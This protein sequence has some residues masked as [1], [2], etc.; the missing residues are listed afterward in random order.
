MKRFKK[1]L[2][3]LIAIV[4]VS[5]ITVM[6][7]SANAFIYEKEAN[8]LNKLGLYKG[9]NESWFDP[10]L[11]ANLDRQTGVVMLLR[12]FGQEDEAKKLTI[13][14]ANS[15]LNKFRDS[16]SI[17]DWSKKQ[18]AY[19]VDKGFVKGYSEDSTFRPS[20]ALNGKAYCSL[21]L[22]QLGYN[23]DFQYDRAAS[24]LSEIGGLTSIQ[25][26]MFNSD[27]TL[28]KDSLVGISY[29]TLQAKYKSNGEKLLKKLVEKGIVSAQKAKEVGLDYAKIVS[30]EAI[31]DVTVNIGGSPKLPT[32]VKA[33]YDDG[34][35]ENVSVSWPYV[36]TSRTGEQT[37]SGTINGTSV[38][39]KV[40]IIVVPDELKV[41]AISSGNLRE[42][43]VK[44]SKPVENED[45]VKDKSNY[46]VDGNSVINA[47]LSDDKMTV[48]LLL[49]NALKQQSD[50]EVSVDKEVGLD[51]DVELYI[52]N[53]KDVT[54]P[55]VV[56][57]VAVGNGLIKV[58]FSEPVQNA[59]SLSSYTIDKK[60]F[61]ATQLSLSNDEKTISINMI[62][63]LS[64]GSH[65]LTVKDKI[66]DYAGYMVEDNET[67]FT[68]EDDDKVPTA[69]I[70]SATQTKVVISFSEEIEKPELNKVDTN[71][72]ANIEKIE[73]DDDNMTLTIYF[74][75]ENALPAS[76]CNIIIED[77]SDFSG[78]SKDIKLAVTPDYD[79]TRPE[80]VGYTIENQKELVLEFSEEVFSKYGKFKLTDSDDD[81]IDLTSATYYKND[82]DE[83]V[84]T[85]LVIK[86]AD[87]QKFESGK[88]ELEIREVTDLN[89][90]KNE[91]IK[92][93]V[94]LTV[95]DNSAPIVSSVYLNNNDNQIFVKFNED[96]EERSA[97]EY[98]NYYYT[99]NNISRK[100]EKNAVD[101]DLLSDDQTVCIT[102]SDDEDDYK[103]REVV[104]VSKISRIQVESVKDIKGNE[105]KA[106]SVSSKD[107]KTDN[108][109][110]PEITSAVVTDKN[111]LVL[112][113][114]GS[115]NPATLEPDDFY[116]AAGRDD[117]GQDI[118]ITAWDALYDSDKSEISL[119]VNADIES[120][121]T[122]NGNSLYLGLE[123][124]E[125]I[126]TEN[127][128]KQKLTI[129]STIKVS[130]DFKPLAKSI[131]SAQYE[132]DTGTV[133]FIELSENLRLNYGDQLNQNDLFQFRVKVNGKTVDAKIYYYHAEGKDNNDTDVD[134]TS[135]RFKVVVEENY[136]GDE[137]Q[138]IFY[139]ASKATIADYSGNALDDFDF[140]QTVE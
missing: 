93:T 2:T 67:S 112:R 18:V 89:P 95:A 14:K 35:K 108:S 75:V 50:V 7:V 41:K 100:L 90:L 135:A 44:F 140:T 42:V 103:D 94:N 16:S 138:V 57:V 68:V 6:P 130:E 127:T 139:R 124:R 43:I 36:D 40:K 87:D 45:E 121:G 86:R 28:T 70:K 97:T 61:G 88:Y 34:T 77:L 17:A 131:A 136:R 72:G 54:T 82:D 96:V 74:D 133:V 80:Y 21:I 46:G 53:V 8:A 83:N 51:E 120:N 123:D 116:I 79:V 113:I 76:G 129:A 52:D 92:K 29:G 55:E 27:A 49:K 3:S 10:D 39:A 4:M 125:D 115:I 128:F 1:V 9:I 13:E 48:T 126:D 111:T 31:S 66:N 119:S 134:E 37:I 19:A 60:L 12:M 107:F 85:K 11:A 101:I 118:V 104:L 91:I 98:S 22:Q 63:R 32:S 23:G 137:V 99:V 56:D 30:V 106:Q 122:F 73:L 117:R 81:T 62:K 20:T 110:A 132:R 25:G 114:K 84:K 33:E 65:K 24:K 58:T 5:S 15:I 78:N 71:A 26:N 59:T 38:T 69:K 102:F 64:S 47:D 105:M 109:N